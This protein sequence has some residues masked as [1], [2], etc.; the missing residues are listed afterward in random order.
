MHTLKMAP[1]EFWQLS[2]AE[3]LAIYEIN[4]EQRRVGA[5]TQGQVDNMA[6]LQ[7]LLDSGMPPVDAMREVKKWR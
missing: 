2:M 6:E 1:S 3:F 7:R 4:R 5:V